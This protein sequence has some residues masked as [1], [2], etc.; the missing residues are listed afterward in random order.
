MSSLESITTIGLLLS[1]LAY[2]VGLAGWPITFEMLTY[3][4]VADKIFTE[5]SCLSIYLG[6]V[7]SMKGCMI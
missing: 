1:L 6:D 4:D 7:E 3:L 2:D 5:Y